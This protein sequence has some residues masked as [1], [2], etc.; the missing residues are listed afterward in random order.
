MDGLGFV[1]AVETF[2]ETSLQMGYEIGAY[3]IGAY[4]IGAY[5]I[6]AYAIRLYGI[7]S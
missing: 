5:A 4:A 7:I 3:A 1:G 2:H 6:R